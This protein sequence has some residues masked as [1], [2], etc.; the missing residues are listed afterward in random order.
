MKEMKTVIFFNVNSIEPTALANKVLVMSFISF[1]IFLSIFL[2]VIICCQK[3]KLK[4]RDLRMIVF[5]FHIFF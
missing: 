3:K 1:I 2:T 5:K 4:R